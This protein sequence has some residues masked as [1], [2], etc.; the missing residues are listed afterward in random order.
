MPSY[1]SSLSFSLPGR[2]TAGA[3]FAH[4][5]MDETAALIG[6]GLELDELEASAE[7]EVG[8]GIALSANGGA[9][10]LSDGNRRASGLAAA[11][12]SFGP[13][14]SAG[15]LGRV[16]SYERRGTGYFSPDRFALAEARGTLALARGAWSGRLNGGFGSQQVGAGAAGQFAWRGAAQLKFRWG[17]VNDVETSIGASNSAASSSTGAYRYMTADVALRLGL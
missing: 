17:P 1:R 8:H 5:P 13:R 11:M 12:H 10:R 14:G 3:G 4:H 9:A 7:A 16:L 2:L 6:S 15:V